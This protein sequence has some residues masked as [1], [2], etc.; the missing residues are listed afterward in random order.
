M[1]LIKLIITFLITV[2][3]GVPTTT[4]Q[5]FRFTFFFL[6]FTKISLT[7]FLI[8][9]ISQATV[10]LPALGNEMFVCSA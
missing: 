6:N 8:E 5:H 4:S 9:Q 10:V 7:R 3:R 2:M 1:L